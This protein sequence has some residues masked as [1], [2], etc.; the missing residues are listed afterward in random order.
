MSTRHLLQ[1]TLKKPQ[2]LQTQNVCPNDLEQPNLPRR[3][4]F[5][6]IINI[7]SNHQPHTTTPV[8]LQEYNSHNITPHPAPLAPIY[9]INI[10]INRSLTLKNRPP[11][12]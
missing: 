6:F 12:I 3:N 1:K 4:V 5:H 2:E 10:P 11:G 8:Y 9:I 7:P